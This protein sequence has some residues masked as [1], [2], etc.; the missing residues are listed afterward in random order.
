M[1]ATIV[2]PIS[3]VFPVNLEVEFELRAATIRLYV[4]LLPCLRTPRDSKK[5]LIIV[6]ESKQDVPCPVP[7][8]AYILTS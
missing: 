5:K 2:K 8:L 7:F 4:N 1:S 6:L 3:H